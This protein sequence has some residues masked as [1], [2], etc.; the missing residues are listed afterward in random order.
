MNTTKAM[1]Q[2]LLTEVKRTY[3][4]YIEINCGPNAYKP[5][6]MPE[7][8]QGSFWSDDDKNWT[9]IWEDGPFQWTYSFGGKI[10]PD[11]RLEAKG[12]Y[13]EPVNGFQL[14]IYNI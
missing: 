5:S 14:G 6:G 2:V 11:E 8:Y 13:A 12:Y 9:V 1:A 3:K 7:L 4:N 10:G